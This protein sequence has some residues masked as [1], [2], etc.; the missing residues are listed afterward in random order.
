MITRG[1]CV[2]VNFSIHNLAKSVK[3][4]GGLARGHY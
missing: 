4:N 3:V 1:I 2:S